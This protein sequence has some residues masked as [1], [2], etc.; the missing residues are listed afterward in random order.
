[1]EQYRSMGASLTLGRLFHKA[2]ATTE[3]A[4]E[5]AVSDLTHLHGTPPGGLAH[6]SSHRGAR[7]AEGVL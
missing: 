2:E 5:K 4:R 3:N 6:M 7:A 1:M